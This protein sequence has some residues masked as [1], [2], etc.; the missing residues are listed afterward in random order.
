MGRRPDVA[1]RRQKKVPL[2]LLHRATTRFHPRQDAR[3]LDTS[4]REG[5]RRGD[6]KEEEGREGA[7]QWSAGG[8]R[9]RAEDGG[10]EATKTEEEGQLKKE[11]NLNYAVYARKYMG[12]TDIKKI[13]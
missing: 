8:G 3:L 4:G 10:T 5:Q 7:A 12:L 2:L 13:F 1:M 11:Y 9:V 6:G